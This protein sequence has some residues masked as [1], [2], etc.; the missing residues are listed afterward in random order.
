MRIG[1]L[2]VVKGLLCL[3]VSPGGRLVLCIGETVGSD[4]AA[5]TF[6][7]LAKPEGH[8]MGQPELPHF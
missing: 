5:A 7:W 2:C 1:P 3:C 6:W 8:D 4:A